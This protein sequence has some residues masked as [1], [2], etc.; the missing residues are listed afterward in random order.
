M[1]IYV[2][3]DPAPNLCLFKLDLWLESKPGTPPEGP[4]QAFLSKEFWFDFHLYLYL[5]VWFVKH[6]HTV[7]RYLHSGFLVFF[8]DITFPVLS[9][10][11]ES[12]QQ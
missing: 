6:L 9:L 12:P 2:P 7:E 11:T 5:M 10:L 3:H 4:I 8:N 1:Y